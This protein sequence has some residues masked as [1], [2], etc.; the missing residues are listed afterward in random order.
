MITWQGQN[1]FMESG[2]WSPPS[3]HV[4]ERP[5]ESYDAYHDRKK[6]EDDGARKVRVGFARVLDEDP[7]KRKRAKKKGKR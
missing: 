3:I 1:W 4:I 7:P 6:A 2:G 5:A